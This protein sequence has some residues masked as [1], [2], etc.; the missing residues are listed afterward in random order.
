MKK[1]VAVRFQCK[2]SNRYVFYLYTLHSHKTWLSSQPQIRFKTFPFS[3]LRS[4]YYLYR[5]HFYRYDS[6][7]VVEGFT[8]SSSLAQFKFF[9]FRRPQRKFFNFPTKIK[10]QQ[11]R[12]KCVKTI[13][14]E[15]IHRQNYQAGKYRE[16]ENGWRMKVYFSLSS[17][18]HSI[19]RIRISFV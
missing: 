8:P 10:K 5:L 6:D 18:T 17:F 11:S 3:P 16:K 1:G 7:I 9:F 12:R 13:D 2:Q 15:E 19:L 4:P 14:K